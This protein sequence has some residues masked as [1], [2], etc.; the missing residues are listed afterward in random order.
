VPFAPHDC[1]RDFTVDSRSFAKNPN[2]IQGARLLLELPI[3]RR[4]VT[5]MRR[6]FGLWVLLGSPLLAAC[7]TTD[8][9]VSGQQ[10]ALTAQE[11]LEQALRGVTRA[12]SF[13]ADSAALAKML[14][15]IAEGEG[16]DCAVPPAPAC[17]PGQVCPQPTTPV[18]E[19][20][21]GELA[22]EDLQ[23]TRDEIDEA[24][25]E[26]VEVLRER[27]F[28]PENLESEDA[29]SATYRLGASFYCDSDD[30]EVPVTPGGT[31]VAP[32]PSGPDP[33]C[34]EQANRWQTRVRLSSP[35]EGDVDVQ[36]LVSSER[37][38][39]ATIELHRDHVAVVADLGEYLAAVRA[40][41]QD[42]GEIVDLEGTVAIELRKNAELDYSLRYGVR[43]AVHFASVDE[44]DGNTVDVSLGASFPVMDIRLDGNQRKLTGTYDLGTL[45]VTLPLE[46]FHGD[47][48]GSISVDPSGNP[49]PPEAPYTGTIDAFLAGIEGSVTLDGTNDELRL[50]NLGL[51][52]ESSTVKYDGQLIA[53]LDV[54]P[55]ANRHFDVLAKKVD[56]EH[57]TLTFAPGL[58]ARVLLNFA[59]LASQIPDLPDYLLGDTIRAF[60]SGADPTIEPS[61]GQ[62]KVVTGTLNL[63]SE[64]VPEA[65]LVV[66]AGSCLLDNEADD[67]PPSSGTPTSPTP[68]PVTPAPAHELLGRFSVGA[69]Q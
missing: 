33:D 26:L 43:E 39:P 7:G 60:F 57:T 4:G 49:L 44:D 32:A 5:T 68:A 66:P 29:T 31:P 18:C 52:D 3:V 2:E 64:R 53:Q 10:F 12:G 50:V 20:D 23:E 27:V 63:T 38:N 35:S 24:I 46:N 65:S 42:T 67:A 56:D 62:V 15:P 30:V 36:I 55:D 13:V 47:D 6:S 19:P 28:T 45:G 69:C 25:G 8:E 16:S 48:D 59:P 37:R 41:G 40:T 21:D 9:Q 14:G 11:N 61:D 22:V 54:N 34:V 1:D 58:D 51:G 17:V